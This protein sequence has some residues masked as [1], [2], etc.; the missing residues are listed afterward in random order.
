MDRTDEYIKHIDTG[1]QVPLQSSEKTFYDAIIT[2]IELINK[3]LTKSLSYKE[4]LAVEEQFSSLSSESQHTIDS[5]SL[6]GSDDL[7][8]H[9]EG[10]K[11]II[12][13]K[14]K[15][16]ESRISKLKDKKMS[17]PVDLNPERP[18][19]FKKI[20]QVQIMEEEN[21]RLVEKYNVEGY[22]L[23]RQRLLEVE[24]LQD[25]IFEHLTL[26]DER[27]DGIV[28][29]ASRAGNCVSKGNNVLDKVGESGKLFRRFMFI[30]LLCM[31]FILAFL[32]YYYR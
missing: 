10:I 14:L 31:S 8:L 11:K 24:A 7:I 3:R 26:Q 9:F 4:L 15:T 28:D 18:Q 21:K 19:T 5:I 6:Q 16:L 27:I 30:L 12:R 20:D 2:K 32:H 22:R 25:T 1:A 17:V 13:M 23:T 29:I